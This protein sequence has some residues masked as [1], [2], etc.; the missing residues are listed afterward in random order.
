MFQFLSFREIIARLQAEQDARAQALV[1]QG[2]QSSLT[3][4]RGDDVTGG[5]EFGGNV[6]TIT[7]NGDDAVVQGEVPANAELDVA[8]GGAPAEPATAPV[9][10]A[11][12]A[13]EVVAEAPAAPAE[14]EIITI[15]PDGNGGVNIDGDV[16]ENAE[17]QVAVGDEVNAEPRENNVI[18]TANAEQINNTPTPKGRVLEG[19]DGRDFLRGGEGNDI[20]S[21]GAGN[22][23]LDG[24]AGDDTFIYNTGDGRDTIANFELLGD[25]DTIQLGVDGIDSLDDFLGTLTR[26][27]DAGDAVL[28]SFDFGGGDRLMIVLESIDSLTQ[29]DFIFV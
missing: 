9:V 3:V 16:P 22:D 17:L 6:V 14:R 7:Q 23:R 4:R 26:V 24:F 29:D 11:P 10:Q 5:T 25:D 28:A 13:P 27:S 21:G 15:T 12:E 20:L 19:G 1:D 8:V 18:I 2:S